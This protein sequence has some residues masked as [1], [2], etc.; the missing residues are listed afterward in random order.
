M[1]TKEPREEDR[2][3]HLQVRE[4]CIYVVLRERSREADRV[5]LILWFLEKKGLK[6]RGS[7]TTLVA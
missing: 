7:L 4:E 3:L 2:E 5:Q 6:G 1:L